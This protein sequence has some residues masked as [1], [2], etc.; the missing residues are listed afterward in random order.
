MKFAALVNKDLKHLKISMG[1]AL[2]L[3]LPLIFL[4]SIANQSEFDQRF[5]FRGAFWICFFV[6]SVSLFYRSFGFEIRNKNFG[7]YSC[8]RVPRLSVFYSQVLV[9]FLALLLIGIF[10]LFLSRLFW[11][12]SDALSARWIWILLL[13]CGGLAPLGSLLSLLLYFEREFLFSI[14]FLPLSIPVFLAAYSLSLE[15]EAAWLWVLAIY[16][17]LSHF[18]CAATFEFFFDELTQT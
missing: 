15:W 10:Y 8:L 3:A 4:I 13:S 6:A 18:L 14:I 17:V 1:P 5:S 9:N 12:P 2:F 11:S 16:G 7:I